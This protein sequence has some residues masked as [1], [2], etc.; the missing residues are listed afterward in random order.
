MKYTSRHARLGTDIGEHLPTLYGLV[1]SLG[2]RTVLELGVR[3][4][5]STVALTEAVVATGGRLHSVDV[6]SCDDAKRLISGYGLG[7]RWS[8]TQQDDLTFAASWDR[9][10]R[11]DFIFIDTSHEEKQTLAELDAFVPL[12]RP[13][14]V[15]AFHD[16]VS[17]PAGVLHPIEKFLAANPLF[18]FENHKNCNG[19]GILRKPANPDIDLDLARKRLTG[20][21]FMRSSD[22]EFPIRASGK[23]WPT[24]AATMIGIARLENIG[25]C[26][27]EI[28]LDSIPGDLIECGTWKG[29]AVT[30]MRELL[31][32]YGDNKRRVWAADSFQGMP[33]PDPRYPIDAASVLH[34]V[35]A[36]VARQEDV[37]GVLRRHGFLD[38]RTVIMPGWFEQTLPTSTTGPLSLLRIDADMYGST[39]QAFESLY[40]RLSPG[41]WCIVDDYGAHLECKK[42]VDDFRNKASIT[43]PIETVD[44]T[45]I[46]WRRAR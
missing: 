7:G 12:L 37:A 11:P 30:Y 38:D 32:F 25:R 14:G 4:G 20:M 13:G 6:D 36:L 17:F 40:D 43:E 5:E 2:A 18:A 39:W 45:A 34:E 9:R 8:F 10:L 33:K 26:V 41:G 1:T 27:K 35:A 42:A 19:L 3:G 29:G 21:F 23:D 31:L 24:N 22:P 16:T 46:C 28:I 15:M 44:W